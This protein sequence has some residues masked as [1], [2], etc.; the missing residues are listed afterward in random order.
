[1][2]LI[3]LVIRTGQTLGAKAS[4]RGGASWSSM[5]CRTPAMAAGVLM[6]ALGCFGP[7]VGRDG[8]PARERGCGGNHKY[9][10]GAIDSFSLCLG[11]DDWRDLAQVAGVI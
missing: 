3:S 9:L 11:A 5:V 1:M 2:G 10:D 7:R 4:E 8:R 6:H